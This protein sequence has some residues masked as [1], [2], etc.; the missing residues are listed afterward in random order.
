MFDTRLDP[1]TLAHQERRPDPTPKPC[2][3]SICNLSANGADASNAWNADPLVILAI[4]RM[5]QKDRKQHDV[6]G[7]IPPAEISREGHLY[8][9]LPS[10]LRLELI[11]PGNKYFFDDLTYLVI[12]LRLIGKM[13][14][15]QCLQEIAFRTAYHGIARCRSEFLALITMK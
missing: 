3:F 6:L 10:I 11:F 5:L 1:E 14:H 2:R 7:S 8:P 15:Q 13:F 12:Q 4:G 9:T